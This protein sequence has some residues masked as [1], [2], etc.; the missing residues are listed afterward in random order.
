MLGRGDDP[1]GRHGGEGTGDQRLRHAFYKRPPQ[2]ALCPESR[3]R[4][5]LL[6]DFLATASRA[7]SLDGVT[8]PDPAILVN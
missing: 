7:L 5:H 4:P 8:G 3:D 6:I 1:T 2:T